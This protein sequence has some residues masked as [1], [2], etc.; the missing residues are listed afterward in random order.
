MTAWGMTT[1]FYILFAPNA[2]LIPPGFP[3]W[4]NTDAENSLGLTPMYYATSVFSARKIGALAA[5]GTSGPRIYRNRPVL[6]MAAIKHSARLVTSLVDAGTSIDCRDEDGRTVLHYANLFRL[7]RVL[8]EVFGL[9]ANPNALD[10]WSNTPLHTIVSTLIHHSLHPVFLDSFLTAG[11]RLNT[12]NRDGETILHKL[13]WQKPSRARN[14][15]E[16]LLAAGVKVNIADRKGVTPLEL[17]EQHQDRSLVNML[18]AAGVNVNCSD[19]GGYSPLATAI[20]FKQRDTARQ[21]LE[22]GAEPR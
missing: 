1:P 4:V 21:L 7:Y 2:A 17:A 8:D 16:R 3:F 11:A 20:R 5:I 9:G 10:I 13:P 14:W 12:R 22:A 15:L 18:L 19:R 6:H